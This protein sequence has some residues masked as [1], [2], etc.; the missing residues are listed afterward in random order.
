MKISKSAYNYNFGRAFTTQEKK[1]YSALLKDTRKELDIKDTCAIV[2]DFNVPSKVGED[3][4]IG[5]TWSE[6]MKGFITFVKDMTGITSIQL[7]P[8]GKIEMGNR[9]P[10]SGTTFAYGEHIIDLSKLTTPEYGSILPKKVVTDLDKNYPADKNQRSYRTNY[11][12]ALPSQEKALKLA[13]S[14]FKNN[15][16]LQTEFSEFKSENANWVEKESLFVALS[17]HYGTQ[18]FSKWSELD[19]NLFDEKTSE[20]VRNS[21]IKEINS[22]YSEEI[23]FEKFVQFIA[24]KQQTE[25]KKEFNKQGIDIYGDC[26]IGFSQ[27]DVWTHKSAFYDNYEFGCE[28]GDGNITCWSPA[29]NFDK[30]HS[31]AGE[32]LYQKFNVFFKRYNGVRVDAAWQLMKPLIAEPR[33]NGDGSDVFDSN[34][35]KLGRRIDR[36]PT[37]PNNGQYIIKDIILKAARDNNVSPDKVFLEL[38]GGA[39]YDSL[40][41]VKGLGTTLIHIT[42]YAGDEWGRVKHYETQNS[43]NKYQ[44]M[45]P[46]DY[47]IGPGSHDDD[48]LIKQLKDNPGRARFFAQDMRLNQ[49]ELERSTSKLA[50][51]A[52]AELFTT[53]NQ[54][55]TLPDILGSERRINQPNVAA[56]NWSYRAAQDY[57][58]QYFENLSNGKGLNAPDAMSKAIK[59]KLHSGHSP[60]TDKLDY[61]ASILREKGPFTRAEADR[62]Y[63]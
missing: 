54:F 22:Q 23:E 17:K 31:E 12:Y 49:Y 3:T 62:I 61:F 45:R 26:Q 28:L 6:S 48:S 47:I 20:Q 43:P 27:K 1:A 21:R 52:F 25:S 37:I 63:G 58:K 42:R 44:N 15:T 41:A 51:A 2:F 46:G 30:I 53:K 34:G 55:A 56:G 5:T 11:E 13:Y 60:L 38:L 9:S 10:Y 32:L 16:S 59:A 57:E 29:L 24:D 8:Q 40:D 39:S 50:D 35:N 7:Q 36:Q 4:A 14:N 19:A 33:K 18:D